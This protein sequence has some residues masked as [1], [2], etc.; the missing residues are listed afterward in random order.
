MRRLTI[1]A[2]LLLTMA[3]CAGRD[4]PVQG[5][6]GQPTVIE[7]HRAAEALGVAVEGA[8]SAGI[9]ASGVVTVNP[10]AIGGLGLCGGN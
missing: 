7:D 1:P 3:G 4:I 2:A 9:V 5:A 8:C 6:D 10:G